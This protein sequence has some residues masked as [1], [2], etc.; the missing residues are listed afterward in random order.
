M[1]GGEG[2]DVAAAARTRPCGVE[3]TI[4]PFETGVVMGRRPA[5]QDPRAL[6]L[7]GGEGSANRIEDGVG[8]EHFGGVAQEVGDPPTCGLN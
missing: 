3:E 1:I 6:G 4:E 7:D 8:I 2:D 5:L